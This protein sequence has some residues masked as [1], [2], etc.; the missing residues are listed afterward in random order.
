MGAIPIGFISR[1][2]GGQF[3]QSLAVWRPLLSLAGMARSY[4]N[5]LSHL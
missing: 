1:D 5:R 4:R 2:L 3:L